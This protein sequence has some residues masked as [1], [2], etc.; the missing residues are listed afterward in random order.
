[1]D[2]KPSATVVPAVDRAIDLLRA[3]VR[4]GKPA[5]LSE[6][7]E[8]TATS[9]ST[10]FNTLATLQAHGFVEKDAR[11]KT[12]RLGLALFELGNAYIHQVSLIPAFTECARQL[13][14]ECGETVKLVMRDGT[15]VIYLATQEAPHSVR[16]VA[17]VGT[18]LPAHQTAVGKVLLAHLS[19]TE[20]EQLYAGYEFVPRTPNTVQNLP[21]LQAQIHFARM[22]GYAYDQEESSLGVNCVAAPIYD[23]TNEAIAAMS[24]GVPTHRL[25]ENRMDELTDRITHY[26]RQLSLTMGWREMQNRIA[27]SNE[28]EY[29]A[30]TE[31]K[32]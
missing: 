2:T 5:T 21:A 18:R 13:V 9:R 22:H 10:A 24:I 25:R 30:Q 29:D 31:Y 32:K 20:L 4:A 8:M 6:L 1:M 19:D 14:A 12:Y 15:D 28:D 27:N 11:F 17:L 7:S 26:A 23:H 16:L 3:I